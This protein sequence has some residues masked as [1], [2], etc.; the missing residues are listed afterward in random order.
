MH[1]PNKLTYNS[2]HANRGCTEQG[3]MVLKSVRSQEPWTR[4][5][6]CARVSITT[7]V[8]PRHDEWDHI[9]RPIDPPGTT[10]DVQNGDQVDKGSPWIGPNVL[11]Q[12]GLVPDITDDTAPSWGDAT[13]WR[14]T[15]F[16][17]QPGEDGWVRPPPFVDQERWLPTLLDTNQS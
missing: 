5:S 12:P 7:L 10:F 16:R 3:H 13:D 9:C 6:C 11:H 8:K 17:W 15:I 2:A 14:S 4:W 1:W